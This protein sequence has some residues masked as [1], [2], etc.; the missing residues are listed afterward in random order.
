M[1]TQQLV[2]EIK[3]MNMS[4]LLLAQQMIRADKSMAVY[5]LGL[6]QEIA[7]LIEGLSA[8]QIIK[9]AGSPV[10]LTRFRFDDAVIL[11]MLTHDRKERGQSHAHAAILLAG[12]ALEEIR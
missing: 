7:Q 9:L 1:D 5:R 11:G 8:A 12:Q 6:S 3:D 2:A 4:Y 10:M